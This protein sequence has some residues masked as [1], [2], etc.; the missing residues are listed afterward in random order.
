MTALG[1]LILA[2]LCWSS[3]LAAAGID[4]VADTTIRNDVG[5]WKDSQGQALHAHA[6]G[7]FRDGDHFYWVGMGPLTYDGLYYSSTTITLYSSANLGQ[8]S[9]NSSAIFRKSAV[10]GPQADLINKSAAL[11]IYRP[12]LAKSRATGRYMLWMGFMQNSPPVGVPPVPQ[13]SHSAGVCVASAERI[14]GDYVLESCFYPNGLPSDDMSV[15][16][17]RGEQYLVRDTEHLFQGISKIDALGTNLSS[18]CVQIRAQHPLPCAGHPDCPTA[19]EGPAFFRAGAAGKAY[20]FTSQLTGWQPNPAM[21]Y[22]GTSDGLCEKGQEFHL[23]GNPSLSSTTHNTQSTFIFPVEHADG[24]TTLL[25]MGD[26]WCPN[27]PQDCSA[28]SANVSNAT[29]VWLPLYP[30]ASAPSGWSLPWL[31][32][33]KIGDARYKLQPTREDTGLAL[34]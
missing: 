12:K 27:Y 8:W 33:W 24:S 5:L 13:S 11:M 18:L 28:L 16:I 1:A 14:D 26:R 2:H 10:A 32:Q 21:L 23:V 4:E 3:S 19:G 34:V 17:D 9:L 15:V 22:E 31:P 7:L 29:Y 20:L 6:G 25:Y 30:N